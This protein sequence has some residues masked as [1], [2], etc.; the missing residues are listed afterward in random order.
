MAKAI[1]ILSSRMMRRRNGYTVGKLVLLLRES[2]YG[3]IQF[4]KHQ[5][6]FWLCNLVSIQVIKGN[7][8]VW[9]AES[10]C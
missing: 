6:I 5:L 8:F 7:A 9:G 2:L 10:S 3:L 1:D 4:P